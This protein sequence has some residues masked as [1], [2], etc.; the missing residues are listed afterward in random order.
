MYD[1]V[2]VRSCVMNGRVKY[3]ASFVHAVRGGAGVDHVALR[4]DLDQTRRANLRVE[5]TEWVDQKVVGVVCGSKS[6][7]SKQPKE[8]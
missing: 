8:N 3:E 7:F 4:V 2:D 5:Q 1:G 6:D